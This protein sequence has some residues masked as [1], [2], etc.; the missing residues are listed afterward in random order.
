MVARGYAGG[1]VARYLL[2]GTVL[3]LTLG[4][5]VMIY[6]ASYAA[7]YVKFGDSAYHLKSQIMWIA[8]G[9]T[10]MLVLARMDYHAVKRIAWLLVGVANVLLMLTLTH[11]IGKWGAQRW[12]VIGPMRLQ[13]S[14]FAKLAVVLALAVLLAD[15]RKRELPFT[16]QVGWFALVVMPVVALI[17]LQ[18]DMG[19][20]MA[21]LVASFVLLALGDVGGRYLIG[22]VGVAAVAIPAMIALEPYRMARFL[23]FLDPWK[24]P[25][26]DGYQI[27]Q[28]L[29]AFGSGGVRG[30]GLGMSR[31]KFFYLPAAHTDFIFAI[32]GEELGLIGTLA[33]VAAFVVFAYAGLRIAIGAKDHL[34]KLLAG[35]LTALI[36]IQ[37][38]MNMAAVTSVMPVTGITLPLVSYGGS[39]MIFTMGC[40]GL[41]LSVSR[42]GLRAE[43][44]RVR[45]GDTQKGI[46]SADTAQRGRD[47]RP[48]LSSI[49]GG[50]APVRKR[51]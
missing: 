17:M 5:L 23:S 16:Q 39:S 25:K 27:I 19:T 7:D 30:V 6:S 31:Q 3:F 34:G 29:Y 12:L 9:L 35:G 24:D 10:A 40:I 33:V 45:G 26:G 41:V 51:A 8:S 4:G 18:P 37:A 44:A 11:G 20:T 13:P 1:P 28:A 47:G 32:I 36:V 14:E 46:P 50:R 48:H 49:D 15:R 38:L 42:H 21:I 43:R 22:L 2:L